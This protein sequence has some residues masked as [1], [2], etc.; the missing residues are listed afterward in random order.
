MVDKVKDKLIR[1]KKSF[2]ELSQTDKLIVLV[3][4]VGVA[5]RILYIGY[6]NFNVRQHDL[7]GLDDN[8][9][10]VAYIVYWYN[11]FKLPD[12]D[13]R[14]LWQFYQPPLHHILAAWWVKLN[15]FVGF[16]FATAVENLQVLT[17]IY[18][19]ITTFICY[20]ILRELGIKGKGLVI[21]F[22]LIC[23]H[24]T[25]ILLSGSIN[26]DIL[27][28][29][30]DVA[31]ILATIKWYKTSSM[32]NMIII[33][34]CLGLSMMTKA[35]GVLIAPGIAVVFIFK[36]IRSVIDWKNTR[37]LNNKNKIDDKK[38][39]PRV[40]V[41][42]KQF[43][44]FLVISVPI[45]IWWSVYAYV[46]FGMPIGYVPKLTNDINQY[47]GSYPTW[48]RFLDFDL[49]QVKSVFENWGSPSF[50]H[51]IL[52]AILKTSLFG[53]YNYSKNSSMIVPFATFLFWVNVILVL[54]SLFAMVYVCLKKLENI[55]YVIKSFFVVM[56]FTIV[57]SFIKFCFQFPHTC[58]MDY[59]Y[60]VP[61]LIIGA[62]AIGL[63]VNELDKK[64]SIVYK[65][66]SY[67]IWVL[68]VLFAVS[69]VLTYCMVWR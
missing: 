19:C 31:A 9:G 65:R 60:I 18:S 49:V 46:R 24:P 67:G 13:P 42:I 7:L 47:I 5:I 51:N 12:F 14:T 68:T 4:F 35:S 3:A 38:Q 64:K 2:K 25:M 62:I 40:L 8:E 1:Y 53:E 29:M 37:Q 45:G 6:T 27:C 15:V 20:K 55:D 59:R 48:K 17:L 39:P 63:L 57:G 69:S 43:V 30:L 41:L 36:F 23:L 34:L 11:H 58:T 66:I 22:T 21:A 56:Y 33:A 52:I 10:H 61:T 16:N 50:E 54:L 26:N 28:L 44:V 32:K